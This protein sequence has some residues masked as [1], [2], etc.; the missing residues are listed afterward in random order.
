MPTLTFYADESGPDSDSPIAVVGGLL[1]R[2]E[3]FLLA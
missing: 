1:L 3:D 2:P